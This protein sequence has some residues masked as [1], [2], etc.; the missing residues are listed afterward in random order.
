MKVRSVLV[1]AVLLALGSCA[2]LWQ[3]TR[4]TFGLSSGEWRYPLRSVKSVMGIDVPLVDG[5]IGGLSADGRNVII[6]GLSAQTTGPSHNL[7]TGGALALDAGTGVVQWVNPNIG[8]RPCGPPTMAGE[9]S[10]IVTL[11][12]ELRELRNRDGAVIR[13]LKI[14][15]SEWFSRLTLDAERVY[16]RVRQHVGASD[17]ETVCA[18]SRRT[19]RPV[20]QTRV[21]SES[22]RVLDTNRGLLYLVTNDRGLVAIDSRSGR[23]RRSLA[24]PKNLDLLVLGNGDRLICAGG[25][26]VV[27][28]DTN[29]WRTM[30]QRPVPV[31]VQYT[32][33]LAT[34]GSFVYCISANGARIEAMNI[35]N[36]RTNWTKAFDVELDPGV[37][38][39]APHW[40]VYGTRPPRTGAD[41]SDSTYDDR[42]LSIHFLD[43]RTGQDEKAGTITEPTKPLS[44]SN[45]AVGGSVWIATRHSVVKLRPPVVSRN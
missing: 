43:T 44:L 39:L 20:W 1:A 45:T 23:V 34:D 31:N 8:R 14:P 42:P 17:I 27:C 21:D 35:A 19:F 40:L 24:I 33:A 10:Y 26:G 29:R 36:G 18:V 5:T 6:V 3:R 37:F 13:S 12:G 32:S 9:V 22:T 41:E 4:T 25:L 38:F 7:R 30:W 16:G 28:V 15:D 11:P 2:F